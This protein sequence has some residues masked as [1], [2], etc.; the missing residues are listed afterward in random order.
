MARVGV[1]ARWLLL[2]ACLAIALVVLEP[3]VIWKSL[4]TISAGTLLLALILA[5]ADRVLMAYKWRQLILAAG[6]H[7]ALG[8]VLWA[9]FQATFAAYVLPSAVAAEIIRGYLVA[10]LGVNASVLLLSMATER[11]I[12]AIACALLGVTALAYLGVHVAIPLV[13]AVA[14]A[15]AAGLLWMAVGPS[16]LRRLPPAIERMRQ[17]SMVLWRGSFRHKRILAINL[18]LASIEQLLQ[19]LVVAVIAHG[20]GLPIEE[21][22]TIATLLVILTVR[23]AIAYVESWGLAEGITIAL[24]TMIGLSA[25]R[26]AALAIASFAVM[27]TASLPGGVLLLKNGVIGA[28]RRQPEPTA[29]VR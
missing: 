29:L 23:R 4:R 5:V 1:V 19:V 26:A 3:A 18:A 20:L 15:I 6:G 16:V 13:I 8:P 7:A 25:E 17:E 22:A 28:A 24:Y 2:I 21:P 10:R 14:C 11:A 27:L 12:G 9:Y